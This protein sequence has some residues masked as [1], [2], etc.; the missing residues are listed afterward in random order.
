MDRDAKSMGPTR[1]SP[2]PARVP[3]PDKGG[4]QVRGTRREGFPHSGD[5]FP[6]HSGRGG[7]MPGPGSGGPHCARGTIARHSKPFKSLYAGECG[8][9]VAI[10]S[11][12]PAIVGR[13]KRVKL[14]PGA[15]DFFRAADAPARLKPPNAVLRGTP[16]IFAAGEHRAWRSPTENR[17]FGGAR[18]G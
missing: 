11:R 16:S 2:G 3:P 12:V 6:R 1:E 4:S 8:Q 5:H 7:I 18:R 17:R 13:L 14:S 15:L 9:G 10:R